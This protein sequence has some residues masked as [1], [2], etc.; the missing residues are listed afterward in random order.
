MEQNLQIL[1]SHLHIKDE[2]GLSLNGLTAAMDAICTESNFRSTAILSLP[3]WDKD[4]TLQNP[5]SILQKC[6]YPKTTYI[7]GGLD[8]YIYPSLPHD[9]DFKGQLDT[10]LKIGVDGIKL[11]ET[12]PTVRK[13]L[14]FKLT[15]AEYAP[16]FE[17]LEQKQVPVLWHTGDP[18]T[19][20][21]KDKAPSW[22]FE[23]GWFYGDGTYPQKEELYNETIEILE[24]YPNLSVTFAHM[25]FA[26]ADVERADRFLDTYKNVR[27]DLTPGS[28]MY[29]NFALNRKDWRSFFI[30]HQDRILFG[31]DGGWSTNEG[32]RVKID[33][34]KEIASGVIRYLTTDDE[35]K[36][37]GYDVLG[38][39]LPNN[40]L[41]KILCDNFVRIVGDKP[42]PISIPDVLDYFE[43]IRSNLTN[44]NCKLEN[45]GSLLKRLD[46][47]AEMVKVN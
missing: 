19:F 45:K 23:N 29:G 11:I 32:M 42:K 38:V 31:T 37:F 43:F 16:F 10:L 34:A 47:I 9:C 24:R 15:S 1:D 25:F 21:D 26:S 20:W 22:A 13:D 7:F 30:K 12:K 5:L 14:G 28:E 44:H 18:E 33:Q 17:G 4:H 40:V 46:E 3:C 39:N 36:L 27:F 8:Y 2:P 35:F 41:K 6:L